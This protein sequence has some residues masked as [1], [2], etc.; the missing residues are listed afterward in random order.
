MLKRPTKTGSSVFVRR[1]HAAALKP[2][3]EERAAA[4]RADDLAVF[5]VH[6][7]RHSLRPVSDE[8]V[9]IHRLWRS[10]QCPPQ[11]HPPAASPGAVQVLV[12]EEDKFRE[13]HRLFVSFLPCPPMR[14]SSIEL[15]W[16]SLQS[17]LRPSPKRHGDERIVAAAGRDGVELVFPALEALLKVVCR[18]PSSASSCARLVRQPQ[19]AVAAHRT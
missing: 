7:R 12:I 13:E 17:G 16:P 5:L 3:G 1:F 4:H 19:R 18:G 9:G 15:R 10:S 11:R 8:P 14:T 6:R 2:R